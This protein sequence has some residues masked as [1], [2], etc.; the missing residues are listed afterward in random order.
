M[1]FYQICLLLSS[2]VLS[3]DSFVTRLGVHKAKAAVDRKARIPV[4]DDFA[5]S[6]VAENLDLSLSDHDESL[7]EKIA[8]QST[9]TPVEENG[10]RLLAVIYIQNAGSNE[11]LDLFSNFITSAL[12]NAPT[13]VEKKLLV[14]A[15]DDTCFELTKR[16][17][18]TN[19]IRVYNGSTS[20]ASSFKFRLA[21]TLLSFNLSVLMMEA[22]QVVLQNP[23][24][25]LFGDC[26]IEVASDYPR[27]S[28]AFRDAFAL[29]QP[30][31]Q[32]IHEIADSSN[33]GLFL[34]SPTIPSLL[35]VRTM[36]ESEDSLLSASRPFSWDQKRFNLLLHGYLSS[37]LQLCYL[38]GVFI[39]GI[40]KSNT[41]CSRHGL[42]LLLRLLPNEQYP[43]GPAYMWGKGKKK[44]KKEINA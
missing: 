5:D 41:L 44:Q 34:I 23:F 10:R 38:G 24:L 4:L 26:D 39:E 17:G 43:L 2:I 35:I 25:G 19:I 11:M 12:K 15:L 14:A 3:K 40:W 28:L 16:L 22:D 30:L 8:S 9:E 31:E 33:I 36:I 42:Q 13:F 20:M 6:F 18:V 37:P 7:I 27:P 32:V 29:D 1:L 21:H